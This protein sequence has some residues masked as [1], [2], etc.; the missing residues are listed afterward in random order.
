MVSEKYLNKLKEA[1]KTLEDFGEVKELDDC[2]AWLL[3]HTDARIMP[4]L[5]ELTDLIDGIDLYNSEMKK[6]GVKD[7]G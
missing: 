6:E 2:Y 7:D 3:R 1:K 4:T 5:V